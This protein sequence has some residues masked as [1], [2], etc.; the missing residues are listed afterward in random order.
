MKHSNKNQR[1]RNENQNNQILKL[2]RKRRRMVVKISNNLT[3]LKSS[4][5][6]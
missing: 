4:L 6:R 3:I 5:S 1:L 2:R